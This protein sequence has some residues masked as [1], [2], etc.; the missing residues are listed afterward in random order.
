MEAR[1]MIFHRLD[2]P[3][4]VKRLS[5]VLL[6]ELC[7]HPRVL[8]I[9]VLIGLAIHFAAFPSVAKDKKVNT[10]TGTVAD[11]I[12]GNEIGVYSEGTTHYITLYA[13]D[14][15]A[16]EQPFGSQARQFTLRV[17]YKKTVIVRVIERPRKRPQEPVFG[18]VKLPDGKMLSQELLKVGLAWWDRESKEK[19]LEQLESEARKARVGLWRDNNPVPPW[20]WR[21]KKEQEI[22]NSFTP[23]DRAAQEETIRKY[24]EHIDKAEWERAYNLLSKR[25]KQSHHTRFSTWSNDMRKQLASAKVISIEFMPD[26]TKKGEEACYYAEVVEKFREKARNSDVPS[27]V[28]GLYYYLIK[29]DGLWKI[30]DLGVAP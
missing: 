2:T 24:Y 9:Y 26:Y 4:R 18:D 5:L 8:F 21:K 10:F 30:K 17:A 28:E 20:E 6:R 12:S 19:V 25:Y 29:E 15:P 22:V 3:V 11:V 14:C 23:E 27:G 1:E 13:I 16:S 7:F